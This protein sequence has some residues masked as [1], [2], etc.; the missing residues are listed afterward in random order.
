MCCVLVRCAVLQVKTVYFVDW[1]F[2]VVLLVAHKIVYYWVHAK[3]HER[4]YFPVVHFWMLLDLL[5]KKGKIITV[6]NL[7]IIDYIF[8]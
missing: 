4:S 2:I 8:L 5:S 1:L 7:K 6:R 3:V